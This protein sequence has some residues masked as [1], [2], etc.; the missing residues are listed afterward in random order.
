M[1]IKSLASQALTICLFILNLKPCRQKWRNQTLE[2]AYRAVIDYKTIL[3]QIPD[4]EKALTLPSLE[5]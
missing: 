3:Q 5:F 2:T 4:K 1:Q